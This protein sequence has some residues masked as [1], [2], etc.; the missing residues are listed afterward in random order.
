MQKVNAQK[1][2]QNV[3]VM[4]KVLKKVKVQRGQQKVAGLKIVTKGKG[5]KNVTKGKSSKNVTK[6][7][8]CKKATKGERS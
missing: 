6:G 3:E 1:T 2:S 8:S 5:S 7:E 4:K